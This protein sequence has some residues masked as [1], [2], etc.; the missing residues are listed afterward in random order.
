M[1][2]RI[3]SVEA[4][5][6]VMKCKIAEVVRQDSFSPAYTIIAYDFEGNVRDLFEF[7]YEESS[8]KHIE[9]I[10]GVSEEDQDVIVDMFLKKDELSLRDF[11]FWLERD[12]LPKAKD[13]FEYGELVSAAMFGRPAGVA[14]LEGEGR[15][16]CDLDGILLTKLDDSLVVEIWDIDEVTFEPKE[17]L[18]TIYADEL[19]QFDELK[20]F[21]KHVQEKLEG[22]D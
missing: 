21:C 18:C 20:D 14:F 2:A 10:V 17:L 5:I 19:S 6:L 13:W 3:K 7:I 11:I 12:R 16:E 8:K 22:S 9:I 1:A 4:Y 15:F